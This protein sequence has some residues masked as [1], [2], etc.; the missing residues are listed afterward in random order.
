MP[1]PTLTRPTRLRARRVAQGLKTLIVLQENT[2]NVALPPNLPNNIRQAITAV[3]DALAENFED[4]KTRLIAQGRYG[5]VEL[6]TDNAC[7]RARL[8]D[9]LVRHSKAGDTIDLVVLGHGSS[10]ELVL[11]GNGRLTG[12]PNGNIRDL[13]ADAAA[14]GCAKLRLRMVYMCNCY[15]STLNDDWLALGAKA[16]VGSRYNDYM[17]EP[18]TTFLL[19][20]W[21]G[22]MK[23]GKAAKEAYEQTIPFYLP[24]YP[25]TTRIKME[26]KEVY[27][28]CPTWDNPLRVCRKYVD[29]P[30]GVELVQNSKITETE[31]VVGGDA[32]LRF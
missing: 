12:G 13:A 4:L 30:V 5:R 14:Q 17:P 9:A 11:H 29:V 26:R 18:M 19:L 2:G 21:M 3:I 23:I 20:K 1:P 25:P 27:V 7:T 31:L 15:G 10:N 32:N 8:L 16:S 6:L 24:F 28:P 22:G